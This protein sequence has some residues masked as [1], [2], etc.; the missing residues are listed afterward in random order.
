MNRR[1]PRCTVAVWALLLS[2]L[3]AG[4]SWLQPAG[5]APLPGGGW[6]RPLSPAL[7]S[8]DFALLQRV[9]GEFGGRRASWLFS[10]EKRG[11]RLALAATTAD[12]NVLFQLTQQGEQVTITPSPLLP[13]QWQPEVVLME[14]QLALWPLPAI[15]ANL[16][17][18]L[19]W[20]ERANGFALQGADAAEDDATEIAVERAA[21]AP[22]QQPV[23]LTRR[24]YHYQVTTLEFEPL[25]AP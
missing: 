18:T 2:S 11:D 21:R 16:P 7:L 17:P 13:P 3:L 24:H 19:L 5:S 12:G 23:R 25:E 20:R 1:V 6:W 14:L 22:W 4:C 9:D 8:T 10:L 15:A